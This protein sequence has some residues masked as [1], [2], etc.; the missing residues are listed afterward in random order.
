MAIELWRRAWA[1]L[2]KQHWPDDR[3]SG[4]AEQ[5]STLARPSLRLIGG[6]LGNGGSTSLHARASFEL[7]DGAAIF[8]A[9]VDVTRAGAEHLGLHESCVPCRIYVRR[10]DAPW[11]AFLE[12]TSEGMK[13]RGTDAPPPSPLS[14][15]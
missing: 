9:F 3:A 6:V 1:T 4:F 7:N 5:V 14:S 12:K 13:A 8:G 10:L 11:C 15:V 2:G